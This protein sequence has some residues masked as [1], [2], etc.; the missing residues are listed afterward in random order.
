MNCGD[1]AKAWMKGVCAALTA[2]AGG[3]T[4]TARREVDLVPRGR[5]F[6]WERT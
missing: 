4:A 6:F 3:R 5:K 2:V 1:A